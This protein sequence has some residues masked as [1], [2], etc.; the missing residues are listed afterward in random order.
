MNNIS[1]DVCLDLIPLV[2]DGVASIDSVNLVEEHIKSCE[3]CKNYYTHQPEYTVNDKKIIKSIKKSV[4][5]FSIIILIAGCLLGTAITNGVNVFYN[6]FIMPS[7]GAL[8]YIIL[9]KKS[10]FVPPIIFIISFL[11]LISEQFIRYKLFSP[12]EIIYSVFYLILSFLGI[13]IAMLLKFAFCKED[14]K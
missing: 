8:S 12:A 7:L 13:I 9:K 10:F 14:K 5:I 1:C 11:W 6:F 3:K 4:Y 2:K